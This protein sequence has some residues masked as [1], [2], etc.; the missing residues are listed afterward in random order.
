[1]THAYYDSDNPTPKLIR[2]ARE[3]FQYKSLIWL[4]TKRNLTIRYK[5][6]LLGAL[7]TMLNPLFT[8]VVMAFVFSII[9]KN[10]IPY[11]S[12]YLLTGLIVWTFFAESTIN[13][14][15]DFRGSGRLISKVYLPQSSFIIVSVLTA[16]SNLLIGIGIVL[17]LALV[18]GSPVNWT[19]LLIPLPLITIFF[20]SFGIALMLAPLGV[21]FS[22]IESVYTILLRLLVYLSAIFYKVD[23]FSGAIRWAIEINP[24]YRFIT[25]F[26]AVLYLGVPLPL[27]TFL[28]TATWA[29]AMFGFGVFIFLRLSDDVVLLL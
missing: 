13:A 6:S 4:L 20:F 16:L 23:M 5:R 10:K 25:L 28:Y 8:M 12:V 19:W 3:L 29:L 7:W 22:D 17:G 15:H 24:L 18:V 14:A 1:M 11:F 26:R 9:L 21:Y 2:E 27:N